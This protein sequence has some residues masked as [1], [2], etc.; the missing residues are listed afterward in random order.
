MSGYI[1]LAQANC[2]DCLRCVRVCPTKAMTYQNHQP[3]I[4]E[5]ECILCGKC[6]QVCPHSAKRVRSDLQQVRQWL[7]ENVPLAI[8]I[9]PSFASVWP[10]YPKLKARLKE[11]GFAIVEET[12]VGAR[13]VSSAYMEL[14][15]QHTMKNILS[16][17]CPAVVSYVEKNF[18]DLVD[19]LAPVVSPMI[20][21]GQDL[22]RRYPG[23]KTVFL[24]PCIAKQK[25]AADPRFAGA[26][27]GVLTM[28][29][30]S[31]WLGEETERAQTGRNSTAWE[32]MEASTVR[33]YPTPG[34]ILKTLSG[35]DEVYE[36]VSAEGLERVHDALRSIR[37]GHM[38]GYFVELSTCEQSCLG[39]PLLCHVDH[40]EWTA[41]SAIRRNMDPQ[42]TVR[43]AS[44]PTSMH[45]QWKPDPIVRPEHSEAEIQDVLFLM[46]K[47]TREKELNCGACG[48]ETCRQKAMAV[49]EGKADP[50]LCL[51][52]ALEHAQSISNLIIENTP[53]GILVLDETNAI[54]EI[55]PAA[56]TMLN[57]Q[58]INPVGLPVESIL[59]DE[60]L[61]E[62]IR[63]LAGVQYYRCDYPQ[64]G[65]IFNH[66]LLSIEDHRYVI[67]ILMDLTVEETKEKLIRQM[68]K[69]TVEVAQ[70]VID[71]Q[72]RGVQEIASLLG[73]TTAKSKVALT[74][75]MKAMNEDD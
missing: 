55:N 75:L 39:G 2:R 44:F 1:Q 12:A 8:S 41:R 23:I 68:Q 56:L 48:Y 64:Y 29:D 70:T 62:M 71:D 67:I 54:R 27:D 63:H 53:N 9:A 26:I 72:M 38:E 73:E 22:K 11:E 32:P 34:G 74:K 37:E 57:L 59:P 7:K 47:T 10:D 52:Y 14:I 5:N 46:G 66:A 19:Q 65:K 40:S 6:Y 60:G 51:P 36:R 20:A 42:D 18:P 3:T 31:G 58:N 17:C 24:T 28:M 61:Q 25:E 49:L 69:N 21:H 50:K 13:L 35:G 4:V 30:L 16:T 15:H 43:K 45:A 33:M